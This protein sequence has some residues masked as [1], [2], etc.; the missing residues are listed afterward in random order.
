MSKIDANLHL[1]ATVPIEWAGYRLDRAAALLFDQFSRSLLQKW[2]KSGQLLCDGQALKGKELLK[3]GECLNLSAIALEETTA[4]AEAIALHIIY[5]DDALLIINKPVGLIVHPGAGNP[6]HTLVN[7]LLHHCSS[8]ST[9]PRAGLVHRLDKDTSGLLV[10]AKTLSAHTHLIRQMQNRLVKRE[11]LAL[12]QGM[13][14]AGGTIN[15]PIGR[16]PQARTRMAVTDSG[17]EA[18]TH[19][20]VVERF[21]AHTLLRVQLETGRTHQIRVHLAHIHH[22]IVG[23]ATYG[24]RPKFPPKADVNLVTALQNFHRQALHATHLALTHPVN[25]ETLSWSVPCPEDMLD[26]IGLLQVDVSKNKGR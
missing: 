21:R 3:G 2:I 18:I 19:Y 22:P 20:R 12:C 15:A 17:R 13:I 16:H 9:L 23:D 10:I 6:E 24:G 4:K 26:L 8:L 25:G 14:T 11:Y 7:A 5:E 1:S